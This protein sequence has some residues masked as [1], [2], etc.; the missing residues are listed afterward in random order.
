MKTTKLELEVTKEVHEI[1]LAVKGVVEAYKI[2]VADG[3]QAGQDI[4]TILMA[5]YSNLTLAIE[6]AD[7]AAAEFKA[8]PI[9]ASLG[10]LIPLSEAVVILSRKEKDSE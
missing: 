10:A 3:F 8:D 2:A 6:G 5:S 4:P 9:K 7:Q 1:G